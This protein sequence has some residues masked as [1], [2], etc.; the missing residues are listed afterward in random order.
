MNTIHNPYQNVDWNAYRPHKT[1]LHC[2]TRVSDGRADFNEMIEAYYADNYDCLSITDHGTIDRGW[3]KP[4][5]RYFV[6]FFQ[7]FCIFVQLIQHIPGLERFIQ[8]H[9]K[10]A[11]DPEYKLNGLTEERFREISQGVGRDGR[12]M[13]RVPLGTEHSPGGNKL[14]HVNSWFCDVHSAAW[15]RA[16]YD[17]AVR[18]VNKAGGLC[19]INHPTAA[20]KNHKHPYHEIYEGKHSAYADYVERLLVQYPALLGIDCFGSNDLKLWDILLQRLAPS[21]RNVFNISTSDSHDPQDKWHGVSWVW[22]MMPQNTAESLRKCLEDGAFF[23]T[24]HFTRFV[25]SKELQAAHPNLLAALR[26][27]NPKSAHIFHEDNQDIYT[28]FCVIP[29]PI[30]APRPMVTS[31]TVENG[32]ISID[33]ENCDA[34]TWISNGKI[35]ASGGTITL[36]ECETLGSYVRAELWGPGGNLYTQP[37]LLR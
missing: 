37:F 3:V 28:H 6:R 33:A 24:G 32:M 10:E 34:I 16:K 23:A 22:A 29:R 5:W 14:A 17:K 4:N 18:T 30:N 25:F 12:G 21:G 7:Y 26:E 8:T 27:E 2:H 13:L 1:E 15:G 19:I 9:F 11:P 36:A 35:I 20:M 31:I